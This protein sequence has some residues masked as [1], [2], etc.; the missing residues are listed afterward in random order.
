MGLIWIELLN[1]CYEIWNLYEIIDFM[2]FLGLMDVVKILYSHAWLLQISSIPN[3]CDHQALA[4]T[5][6]DPPQ[7]IDMNEMSLIKCYKKV[8]WVIDKTVWK[9][10]LLDLLEHRISYALL[11][12]WQQG[13]HRAAVARGPNRQERHGC[14]GFIPITWTLCYPVLRSLKDVTWWLH[15]PSASRPASNRLP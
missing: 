5:S 13:W 10:S 6:K 12:R 14:S 11:Y 3:L 8:H 2:R 15:C 9:P 7:R 1:S 4:H